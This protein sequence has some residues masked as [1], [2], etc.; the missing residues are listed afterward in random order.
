MLALN[1]ES[2]L[3]LYAIRNWKIKDLEA[4]MG[5]VKQQ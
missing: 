2:S 4:S 1:W 5:L 3:L